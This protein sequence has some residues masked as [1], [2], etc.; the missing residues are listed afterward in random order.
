MNDVS[1]SLPKVAEIS[2]DDLVA[3]LPADCKIRLTLCPTDCPPRAKDGV[4]AQQTSRG[5]SYR[6]TA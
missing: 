1:L 3:L 2:F 6:F 4:W 5:P